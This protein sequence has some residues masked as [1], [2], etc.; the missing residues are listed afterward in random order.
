MT[1]WHYLESL[2]CSL[3]EQ[4]CCCFAN[5]E[6]ALLWVSSK[7]FEVRLI[8]FHLMIWRSR[9]VMDLAPLRFE[10]VLNELLKLRPQACQAVASLI[11]I[12]IVCRGTVSMMTMSVI[13]IDILCVGVDATP[14]GAAQQPL[15]EFAEVLSNVPKQL[16]WSNHL[17]Q[18]PSSYHNCASICRILDEVN[19]DFQA[20]AHCLHE[21]PFACRRSH[22]FSQ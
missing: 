3:L 22:M 12:M 21:A 4:A 17:T 13:G 6:D 20:I 7:S 16:P 15:T 5:S 11:S 14:A 2:L 1:G 8:E 18:M 9:F 19:I 10:A